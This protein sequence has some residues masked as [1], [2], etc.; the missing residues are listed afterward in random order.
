M[1]VS[2]HI[3]DLYDGM[4]G[5]VR[6]PRVLQDVA[7]VTC[8]RL[9]SERASIFLID[10]ETQELESVGVIGN[11]ARTIRVPIRKSS[12]AGYC[13]T[14]G[15]AFVV[16][17]AYGDLTAID[18]ELHFDASWDRINNFRTRDV[19][20]A[21][22]RF[23]D[24][25]MGVV[26]VMNRRGRPFQA[27][28]LSPLQTIS[29]LVGYALYHAR[30][31]HDL[32]NLK[33]LEKEKAEFMRIMVHELKAPV[34]VAKMLADGIKHHEH[35]HPDIT[36][37]ATRISNRLAQMLEMIKKLLEL[38]KVKSGDP[39]GEVAVI[40]LVPETLAGCDPYREQA[41]QKGLDF[42]VSTPDRPVCIRF[43]SQGYH[44][45]LSNLVSNAVKYT[46][47]GFVHVSLKTDEDWAVLEVSDS[48]MG[49]PEVDIPKLFREF[50][51]AS[52]AKSSKV[53][54]SGV[55]LA[56]AKRLVERFGG[57]FTLQSREGKGSTFIVRFPL[58]SE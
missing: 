21:P 31:Y 53:Q 11:V 56:T 33:R 57:Q 34:G 38:A 55:G 46:A 12:L 2:Q 39:F 47:S 5:D 25:I 8:R 42:V 48:G 30:L 20:C 19:M 23:K 3:F 22:A 24:Q 16:P 13:A 10:H 52:N 43:D 36:P 1:I 26:E 28:D 9:N 15:R 54:G 6:I 37:I 58:H 41:E 49:I 17:D 7:E 35:V 14:T 40:D 50:F 32:M 44:L 27:T 18:P 51:R 4:L 29:R 45:V